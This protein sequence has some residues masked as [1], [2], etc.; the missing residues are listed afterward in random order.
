TVTTAGISLSDVTVGRDLQQ[1]VN[2]SLAATPPSPVTV[3][4]T[5][6][7]GGISSITR[8]GT[9]EGGT[10]V[11]FTNVT[12]TNVGTL[13]VQGRALGTTTLTAQASGYSDATS[14]VTVDPSGFIL[15]AGDFST[16]AQAANSSVR[17][18]ASRLQPVTLNYAGTQ[19]LRGGITASV[20]VS[21]SDPSVGTVTSP[22][23][24]GSG[25]SVQNTVFNPSS[26]GTTT[27]SLTMPP[28]FTAPSNFQR[29]TATVN[30]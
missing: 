2:I 20:V 4:I 23:V 26:P 29:L 9:V 25:D 7:N 24:F 28:G 10:V 12:T 16:T 11:T 19:P 21:S 6:A 5:S 3:T 27:I 8:D 13:V 17:I 1:T 22:I 30:P 15:N 18:D 14:T